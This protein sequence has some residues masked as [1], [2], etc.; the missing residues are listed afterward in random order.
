MI[1]LFFVKE[2]LKFG[3]EEIILSYTY[4]GEN[5]SGWDLKKDKLLDLR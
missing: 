2:F 1:Q 4:T 3:K 5:I